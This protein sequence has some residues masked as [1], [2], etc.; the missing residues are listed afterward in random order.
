MLLRA[1]WLSR[2]GS[3][4][5]CLLDATPSGDEIGVSLVIEMAGAGAPTTKHRGKN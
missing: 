1:I 3:Q 2:H 4:R 5:I